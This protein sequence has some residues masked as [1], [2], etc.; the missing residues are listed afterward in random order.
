MSLA[1]PPGE[2][3]GLLGINGAGKSST[4][5]VLTGDIAPTGSVCC[6]LLGLVN[7][8][9]SHDDDYNIHP[10]LASSNA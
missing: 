9:A 6:Y 8:Q 2:T 3:F 7:E 10:L 4:L 1:C 5:N